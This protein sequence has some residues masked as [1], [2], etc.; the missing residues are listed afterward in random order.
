MAHA[1][2]F[3]LPVAALVG[4]LGCATFAHATVYSW[5]DEHGKLHFCNAEDEVPEAHRPVAKTFKSR[6]AASTP[7]ATPETAPA[8]SATPD[9][10][11]AYERGLERGLQTA[12]RQVALAGE[13]ARTLLAAAQPPP[14]P[15]APPQI[16]IVQQPAPIVR[17]VSPEPA[18]APPYYGYIGP[19][20]TASGFPY[21]D[22]YAYGF[23]RGRLIRHSHFFPGAR[24]RGP[25]LYF[26]YG[27]SR[28]RGYLFGHGFVVR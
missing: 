17:Y 7:V 24:R 19:Y 25:G 5:R 21:N 20:A 11:S 6:L 13:L 23:G 16:I 14:P 15:P 1:K 27:H 22:T 26:P 4:I 10:I 12:E 9:P 28:H 2:F 8:P 18:Y 3:L